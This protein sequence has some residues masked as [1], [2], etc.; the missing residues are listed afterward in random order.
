MISE[1]TYAS[2]F[3]GDEGGST[4]FAPEGRI[5][6]ITSSDIGGFVRNKNITAFSVTRGE[7]LAGEDMVPGKNLSES[8]RQAISISLYFKVCV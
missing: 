5:K 7:Q 3:S 1:E 2:A 4:S 6:S 8:L